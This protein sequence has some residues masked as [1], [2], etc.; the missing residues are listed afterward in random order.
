M[1]EEKEGKGDK[2]EKE[3]IKKESLIIIISII[4]IILKKKVNKMLI[5]RTGVKEK[6]IMRKEYL[7]EWKSKEITKINSFKQAKCNMKKDKGGK[8]GIRDS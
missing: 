4:G 8:E 6:E 1:K 5:I 2:K 7:M 3:D